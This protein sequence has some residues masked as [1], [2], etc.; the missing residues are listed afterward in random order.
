MWDQ[1]LGSPAVRLCTGCTPQRR[2]PHWRSE[3]SMTVVTTQSAA[4]SEG[5]SE[6]WLSLGWRFRPGGLCRQPCCLVLSVSH[7]V[8]GGLGTAEAGG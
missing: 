6:P 7:V 1:L 5:L 8:D 3:A 4:C 2:H